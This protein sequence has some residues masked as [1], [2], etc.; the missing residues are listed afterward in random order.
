[1]DIA[2]SWEADEQQVPQ[3][4]PAAAELHFKNLAAFMEHLAVLYRRN[5][6]TAGTGGLRWCPKWWLHPEAFSRLEALWR[7]WEHLRLD[8]QTGM[9]VW[10][11]D[12]AD[13]HMARLMS[14][15]GPFQAC[16]VQDGHK[17]KLRDL[18]LEF[19]PDELFD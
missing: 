11:R 10:W 16:N 8:G 1:M 17:A 5:I 13:P 14:S 18:P 15:D 9:S 19:P 3:E 6:D 7:S 12:H 4:H 2:T